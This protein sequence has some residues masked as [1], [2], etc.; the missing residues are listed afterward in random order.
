[1]P[2]P[3][4]SVDAL[5][6]SKA[7]AT[8]AIDLLLS[9]GLMPAPLN[10]AVAYEYFA[11]ASQELHKVVDEHLKAGR[12]LDEILLQDLYDKHIATERFKHFHGMRN[13]LQGILQALLQTIT[14]TNSNATD[15]RQKLESNIQ[16]L[17]TEQGPEALE[18]IAGNLLSAT[19]DTHA[20][21]LKLQV[22]LDESHQ[23]TERLREELEIHRREAMIDPLTGLFN[24]RAMEQHLDSLMVVDRADPLSLLLMDI[25]HFKHVN[26]TYG[27]A[28]GDIVIRNVA[29][30][31]RKCIRG[32]DIA[33]RFGG[34]EF[35]VLLPNT[36]LQGAIVVAETI[37]KRIE[38]LR[39]IRRQDNFSL[40]PF[41]ISLGV[42]EC[43]RTTPRKACSSART[44][45]ST[46]PSQTAATG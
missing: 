43:K 18:A 42:A 26:D 31:V 13:D 46:R 15:Y 34:E 22:H 8:L 20:Q 10:Y 12:M 24:R 7:A 21:N 9:H 37:R 1:M 33:I 28:I 3:T 6:K 35:L 17:Q 36:S 14:D 5:E 4:S 23:E 16:R 30:T 25:D 45:P 44:R 32:E 11:G 38:E 2:S 27:H 19:E 41:T 40:D 39:L 29:N